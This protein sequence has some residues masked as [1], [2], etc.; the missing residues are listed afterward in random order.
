ME[1]GNHKSTIKSSNKPGQRTI[2]TEKS[3]ILRQHLNTILTDSNDAITVQFLDGKIAVWNKGAE[4]MYG[5][6]EAE[7]LKMNISEIVPGDKK[8][9]ALNLIKQIKTGEVVESLET[10][11]VTKDGKVLDVWLTATKMTEDKGNIIAVATTERDITE[12]NKIEEE[13]KRLNIDLKNKNRELEEIMRSVSHDLRTPIINI[14][15]FSKK[16]ENSCKDMSSIIENEDFSSEL[17]RTLYPFLADISES[18]QYV[19]SSA[20]NMESLLNGFSRLLRMGSMAVEKELIDMNRL[21]SRVK[22]DFEL[23]IKEAGAE[24]EILELPHCIG[25]EL[26]IGQL[27][28]NLF[29]NAFKYLDPERTGIIK[30]SGYQ[31]EDN[32]S[33]YCV[34]DNGIGIAPENQEKIFRMFYQIEPSGSKG[35]GLGLS[36][37]RKIIEINNGEIY[38]ES[39]AGKGSKF[40]VSLPSREN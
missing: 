16:L 28:S 8:H 17:K 31:K 1:N 14:V 15:G 36:I 13:M 18:L 35:Q 34:E 2:E 4:K 3:E 38:V 25:D 37:A 11:R 19:C 26:Q 21:I 10:Q 20:L 33:V 30:V 24:L 39:E 40:F 7:A 22:N 6:S 29:S 9:E 12:R 23:Q 27:F 5:Y 32:R